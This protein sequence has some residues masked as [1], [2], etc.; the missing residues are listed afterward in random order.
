MAVDTVPQR[1]YHVIEER[2]LGTGDLPSDEVLKEVESAL[3]AVAEFLVEPT[4]ESVIRISNAGEPNSITLEDI[5]RLLLWA[6]DVRRRAEDVID[7]AARVTV[8]VYDSYDL[9]AGYPRGSVSMFTDGGLVEDA[10]RF[11][12]EKRRH[13]FERTVA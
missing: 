10:E 9:A 13:G 4:M 2:A 8:A 3:N 6:D 11:A 7:M 5:G 1:L 12:A